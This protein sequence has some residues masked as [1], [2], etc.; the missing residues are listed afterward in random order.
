MINNFD[1][2]IIQTRTG[3]KPSLSHKLI[4]YWLSKVII[5]YMS[6]V[7]SSLISLIDYELMA[8]CFLAIKDLFLNIKWTDDMDI[9]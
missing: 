5:E 1:I 2:D 9:R 7:S 4:F 6:N 3:I 8:L